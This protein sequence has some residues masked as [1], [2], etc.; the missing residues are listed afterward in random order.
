MIS[1]KNS[2]KIFL[3]SSNEMKADRNDIERLIRSK[4]DDWQ[5]LGRPYIDL[6]TW[7]DEF[8]RS[9]KKQYIAK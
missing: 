4:N 7:E 3:A 5:K 6:E 1:Q 9:S 2:L 8:D